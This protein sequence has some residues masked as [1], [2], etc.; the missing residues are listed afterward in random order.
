MPI[1]HITNGVQTPSWDSA[2]ADELWTEA[3]GQD[4]WLGGSLYA[5]SDNK[6]DPLRQQMSHTRKS[7]WSY[8]IQKI[9][10]GIS[11]RRSLYRETVA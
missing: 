2:V 10:V 5:E 7:G 3:C 11:A 9:S 6:E 1:G 4:R 8:C